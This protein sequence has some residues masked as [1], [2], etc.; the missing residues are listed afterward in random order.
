ML[1]GVLARIGQLDQ[2]Y[3]YMQLSFRILERYPSDHWMTRTLL[4]ACSTVLPVKEPLRTM[5]K[6]TL[7]GHR[8]GL[9]SGEMEA[10]LLCAGINSLLRILVADPLPTVSKALL[11]L[12]HLTEDYNQFSTRRM[13][14]FLCQLSVNLQGKAADPLKFTG[15]FMDEEEGMEEAKRENRTFILT[16][17]VYFRHMVAFYADA[18]EVADS[19]TRKH[20]KEFTSRSSPLP[21]LRIVFIFQEGLVAIS[22][23]GR[24]GQKKKL[25]VA[26]RNLKR[27]EAMVIDCPE[28]VLHKAHLL[29]GEILAFEGQYDEAMCKYLASITYAGKA[30]YVNEEAIANEKAGEMLLRRGLACQA[31][32]FVK[33]AR[34][35]Y[36]RW[37]AGLK[38]QRMEAMIAKYTVP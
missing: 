30:G 21:I 17:H 35:L 8:L 15:D 2:G 37:G 18:Y 24:N 10:G 27:L 1:G 7:T 12:L 26:R 5:I 19:I 14:C 36:A 28:N 22:L 29:R 3:R 16:I 11:Q 34:D 6:P 38:V 31:L 9:K 25:S 4:V 20:R 32:P 23:A 33:E 13:V